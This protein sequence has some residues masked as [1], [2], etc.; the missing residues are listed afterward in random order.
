[1]KLLNKK[2]FILNRLENLKKKFLEK[3]NMLTML[4]K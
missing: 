2:Q 4:K 1:M 3:K